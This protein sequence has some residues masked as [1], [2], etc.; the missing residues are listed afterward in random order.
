MFTGI[1]EHVGQL[2]FRRPSGPGARLRVLVPRSGWDLALG[3]SVSVDGVCLT[4]DRSG[5]GWLEASCSVETLNVTT[6]ARR[7]PGARLNLER[8]VPAA[9]RFGGHFVQGHVDGVGEVLD[10]R[11]EGDGQVVGFAAP[12]SVTPYLVPR[13][14][15]AVNG[16]SLT[17]TSLD[18]HR[19]QVTLIPHTLRATNLDRLRRGSR[20]NLEAD[21]LGKYVRF[22][23]GEQTG[24]PP[25]PDGRPDALRSPRQTPA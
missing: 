7:R 15:I 8:A 2:A 11:R 22:F 17:I 12:S 6:L 24:R 19:F 16:V 18:R 9:G 5:P 23:F 13:G 21:I 25:A 4:V 20:V 10:V 14:S 3:E 1:I